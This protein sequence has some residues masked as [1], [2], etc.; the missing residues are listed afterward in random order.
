MTAPGEGA[1]RNSTLVSAGILLSRLAGFV[2]LRALSH[3][4][5][6]GLVVDAFRAAFRIP[7]FLQNLLGEGV[8]SASFI[9]VY[10]RLLAEG[11]EEEAAASRG[12]SRAAACR[13]RDARP[14]RRRL[15][16][17]LTAPDRSRLRRRGLRPDRHA[18]A[19]HLPRHRA[20]RAVGVVPGAC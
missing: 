18:D 13:R 3:F 6:T 1:R 16:R 14:D 17:P 19:D 12:R 20:A 10:S 9:P 4:L 2:R 7:N 15:R 11:R 8:L 5:G